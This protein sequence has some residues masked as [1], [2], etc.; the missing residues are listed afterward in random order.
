[1]NITVQKVDPPALVPQSIPV[2][3]IPHVLT[4]AQNKGMRDAAR[5]RYEPITGWNQE[6]LDAYLSGFHVEW[7]H[8]WSYLHNIDRLFEYSRKEAYN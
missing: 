7:S 1:M 5:G 8:Q 3:R 2:L 6:A 4:V